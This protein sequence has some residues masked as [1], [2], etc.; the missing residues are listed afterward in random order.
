[1]NQP[2]VLSPTDFIAI[3]NQIMENAFSGVQIQGELANFKIS[4]NRWVF[5]DLKDEY[6]KVACFASVYAL[7]GPLE[8]GMMLRVTGTPKI[9]PQYGFSVTVQSI[10]PSGEGSIK[11][12]FELLKAKLLTEGLFDT[13]RKRRLP[14]PPKKVALITSKES[15]AYVDFKK[16]MNV[17]WP[18]IELSTYDTQVQ[19]DLAIEQ[20]ISAINT[21]NSQPSLDDV[22]VI[23]RGGGSA[24]DMAVFNDE[25]LVRAISSSRTPTLVAIG[26]EV[27]ESLA[28]TVADARA[29]TPSNAAELLVPDR[30]AELKSVKILRKS[31]AHNLKIVIDIENKNLKSKEGY[32]SI[33]L[34]QQLNYAKTELRNFR[35]IAKSYDPREILK[36]GYSIIKSTDG[37][38]I[39][40][41]KSV[42]TSDK[43]NI[44]LTDGHIKAIVE[45]G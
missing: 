5:F 41:V 28:E 14:Y 20:I 45:K 18:F 23:T 36:R 9:H 2:M 15:A 6:S 16:V 40:S 1:M 11:K 4:K 33:K 3:S 13:S 24:D 17:R 38:I 10:V 30:V 21:V 29:S 43:I 32:F 37:S 39:M 19:G 27:D 25:N 44:E 7:P 22:L 12:A 34:L 8:E 31:F 42:K 26:H 35:R